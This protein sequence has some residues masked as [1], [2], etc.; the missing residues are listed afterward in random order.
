MQACNKIF[1][2]QMNKLWSWNTPFFH[3][4]LYQAFLHKESATPFFRTNFIY[5]IIPISRSYNQITPSTQNPDKWWFG[6]S[7]RKLHWHNY[8]I[9][10]DCK[11][12]PRPRNVCQFVNKICWNSKTPL[13]RLYH[14]S[15][16]AY[17]GWDAWPVNDLRQFKWIKKFVASIVSAFENCSITSIT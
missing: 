16:W 3:S 14:C 17:D 13:Q 11:D 9:S 15:C 5:A 1:F 7:R 8:K 6:A 12:R 4:D 2:L 10:K